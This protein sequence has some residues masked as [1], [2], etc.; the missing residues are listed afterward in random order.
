M[1]LATVTLG[2]DDG[3]GSQSY[4]LDIAAVVSQTVSCSE[5]TFVLYDNLLHVVR[6][7]NEKPELFLFEESDCVSKFGLVL[8]LKLGELHSE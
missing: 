7:Q 1:A 2:L 4:K 8:F 5:C 6:M 3:T